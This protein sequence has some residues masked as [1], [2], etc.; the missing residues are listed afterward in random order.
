MKIAI[1]KAGEQVSSHYG[2][3]EGFLLAELDNGSVSSKS[4]IQA[5]TEHSCGGLAQLF[6]QH[7]VDTVI[8]G[9]IGGG[10][11]Q[12][13]NAAGI[14]IVAGASGNIDEVL[15]S[16]IDGTLVPGEAACGGHGQ[17]GQCHHD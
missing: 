15:T 8:V 7:K 6:L 3:S 4:V 11:I 12:H 16:Y 13:L 9:G 14:N 17:P 2:Q 10:A 1:V 5:P